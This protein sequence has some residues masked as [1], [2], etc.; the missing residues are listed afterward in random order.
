MSEY[1]DEEK[2]R[3]PE[4]KRRIEHCRSSGDTA[5]S[6]HYLGLPVLPESLRTLTHLETLDL[7]RNHIPTLPEWLTELPRLRQLDWRDNGPVQIPEWLPRMPALETLWL[8]GNV[9]I[10]GL[11]ILPKVSTLRRLVLM[12]M[13]WEKL[14]ED[15]R[16]ASQITTLQLFDN[17]FTSLPDWLGEWTALEEL[18]LNGN[19]LTTLPPSF[20]KLTALRTLILNGSQFSTVPPALLALDKLVKLDLRGNPLDGVPEELLASMDAQR[21]LGYVRRTADARAARP[22]RE[23]KVL[24]VGQGEVGKTSL[25][26]QLVKEPHDPKEK[27]TEG[28]VRRSLPLPCAEKG[29]VRLNVWDFGGQE[30]M[31]ST[32]QFFLTARSVYV[33]VLDS[34]QDERASRVE[35]WLRLIQSFG[36]GSPVIVVCNK[37]DEQ[38]MRLAWETLQGK[39]PQIKRYVR[40]VS[41]QGSEAKRIAPGH[42]VAE[43][44]TALAE[45]I[46]QH[47]GHIDVPFRNEWT[48]LKTALEA[49]PRSFLTYAQYEE[50]CGK[51][52][53]EEQDR[54]NLLSYLNDLGVM[55]HFGDHPMMKDKHVLQPDWV[56]AAIYRALNDY[57]LNQ[58]H[59]ELSRKELRRILR[60]VPGH[61]YPADHEVFILEMMRKFELCF[62]F[63]HGDSVLMPDLL[64]KDPPALWFDEAALTFRYK[65]P[66]LPGSVISRFIV[67]MHTHIAKQ[68]Y[69][70]TGVVLERDGNRA[71]VVADLEDAHIDIRIDGE[72][73]GRRTLLEIIR[74]GFESIHDAFPERLGVSE[75]VPVPGHDAELLEYATL[76]KAEADGETDFYTKS[77]GRVPLGELLDGVAE[78][79]RRAKDRHRAWVEGNRDPHSAPA[80]LVPASSPDWWKFAALTALGAGLLVLAIWKIEKPEVRVVL[81]VFGVV[82]VLMMNRNPAYH[83]RRTA[84][85]I[86]A[87]LFGLNALNFTAAAKWLGA[88]ADTWLSWTSD[89]SPWATIGGLLVALALYVLDFLQ[90]RRT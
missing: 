63:D 51:H 7:E 16:G 43:V 70:L 50:L 24:V 5:L 20:A 47:V 68:C 21:I 13:G 30:I 34:R 86:L 19:A 33:L 79:S 8:S 41:C 59:G 69:W 14:P 6:L 49:D 39:Y 12:R 77:R 15:L 52:G 17:R 53:V 46:A 26:R 31:H 58:Q 9:G 66:V 72:P 18:Y 4:E 36:G 32:H 22:L 27:K 88:G 35:Y 25:I 56:T 76:V 44:R 87:G 83:Y 45:V 40:E 67:R 85:W 48:E 71:K 62:R 55:L 2:A 81:S 3:L 38:P 90:H 60:D 73:E 80:P 74:A 42:G 54:A 78:H 61:E 1:T 75:W 23:V 28:I 64:Q 11:A 65:Y 29:E 82:F 89:V 84:G 37:Y 57:K 10:G